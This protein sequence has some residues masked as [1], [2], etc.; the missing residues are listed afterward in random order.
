M[1]SKA[2][3]DTHAAALH[4][5]GYTIV[6]GAVAP[7]LVANLRAS[8]DAVDRAQDL[9][10]A[11]SR[12]EGYRTVRMDNLRAHGEI[13][14]RVPLHEHVLPIAEHFLDP[15]LLL[16]SLSAITLG[17]GQHL[18]TAVRRDRADRRGRDAGRQRDAVRQ[19][20]VACRRRQYH[21]AT[22]LRDGLLLMCGLDAP[23]GEPAARRAD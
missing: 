9:G 3:V 11:D 7:A 8:L 10:D 22:P 1:L 4:E 18:A 12:F 16:S 19:P 20:A 21:R 6:E 23:A 13:F 5:Q 17:P 14:W 15:E 2:Q